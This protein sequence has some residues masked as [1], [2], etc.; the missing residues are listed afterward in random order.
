M[1]NLIVFLGF[2]DFRL[3][4]KSLYSICAS[5]LTIRHWAH[6]CCVLF[7][8]T[9][10][11]LTERW[12]FKNH[13]LAH[14]T[15]ASLTRMLR[16]SHMRSINQC[17]MSKNNAYLLRCTTVSSTDSNYSS[18]VASQVDLSHSSLLWQCVL[19]QLTRNQCG[20]RRRD[21][22]CFCQFA[23]QTESKTMSL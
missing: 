10:P 6:L 21:G 9:K 15:Q 17:P 12:R 8:A 22:Q 1:I 18:S 11:L 2:V 5:T 16:Q 13:K 3:M 23:F 7:F 4:N 19:H 20:A 14:Q